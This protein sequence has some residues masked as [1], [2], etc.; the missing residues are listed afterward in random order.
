[1]AEAAA[2]SIAC[3]I[4][5]ILS[6]AEEVALSIACNAGVGSTGSGTCTGASGTDAGPE[7]ERL[8][9]AGTFFF[10]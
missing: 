2:L 8:L 9:L 3:R 10:W 5:S 6:D 4:S 1:M 7:K